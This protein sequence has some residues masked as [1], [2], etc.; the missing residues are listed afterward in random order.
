VEWREV[1]AYW[2]GQRE[3][4]DTDVD[5][6]DVDAAEH[7]AT[8]AADA[9][10][11]VRGRAAAVMMVMVVVEEHGGTRVVMDMLGCVAMT[12]VAIRV[13]VTAVTPATGVV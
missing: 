3:L 7:R 1:C 5:A 10:A 6:E 9:A 4:I 13:P 12:V 11:C 2:R 8:G